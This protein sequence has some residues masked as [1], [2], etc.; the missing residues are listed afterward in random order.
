MVGGQQYEPFVRVDEPEEFMHLNETLARV[1]SSEIAHRSFS[2]IPRLVTAR[3]A[4]FAHVA[5]P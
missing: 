1:V 5:L 4:P 3:Y 2:T